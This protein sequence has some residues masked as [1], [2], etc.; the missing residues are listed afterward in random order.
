MQCNI[1]L[2]NSC[3]ACKNNSLWK[4][5][6]MSTIISTQRLLVRQSQLTF[7]GRN[8]S[9]T[10]IWWL[11]SWQV[12]QIYSCA[13]INTALERIIHNN[14]YNSRLLERAQPRLTQLSNQWNRATDFCKRWVKAAGSPWNKSHFYI[15]VILVFYFWINKDMLKEKTLVNWCTQIFIVRY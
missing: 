9:N 10:F 7:P 13:H 5:N 14:V 15:P 12:G 4:H 6:W 8:F 3:Q 11:A 2:P 1:P